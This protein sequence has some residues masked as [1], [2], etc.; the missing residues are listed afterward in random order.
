MH[1]TAEKRVKKPKTKNQNQTPDYS[2]LLLHF[3][4]HQNTN[5]K[6]DTSQLL[7]R[8]KVIITSLLAPNPNNNHEYNE[9]H[10]HITDN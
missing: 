3:Q 2:F 1:L 5:K 8:T 4:M 10:G 7:G 9:Q 6:Q